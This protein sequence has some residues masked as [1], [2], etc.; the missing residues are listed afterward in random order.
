MSLKPR[1]DTTKTAFSDN[2]VQVPK[3]LRSKARTECEDS[4]RRLGYRT[5]AVWWWKG[6][7][8]ELGS[9]KTGKGRCERKTQQ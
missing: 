5:E 1:Y 3:K 4:D 6:G 8:W 7:G 9:D 2:R